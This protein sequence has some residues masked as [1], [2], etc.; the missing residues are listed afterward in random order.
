MLE[1]FVSYPDAFVK[2]YREKGLWVDK[3]IGEES[4]RRSPDTPTGPRWPAKAA[5]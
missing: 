2:L 1:G 4:T 5:M 3:T